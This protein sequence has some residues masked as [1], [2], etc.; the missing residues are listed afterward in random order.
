MFLRLATRLRAPVADSPAHCAGRLIAEYVAKVDAGLVARLQLR[1][2]PDRKLDQFF[3]AG[4][5]LLNIEQ[6][7]SLFD[8]PIEHNQL[9]SPEISGLRQR[10]LSETGLDGW[11]REID[12][13]HP[14][15]SPC[16]R[17][18]TLSVQIGCP[19]DLSN[20]VSRRLTALLHRHLPQ[21]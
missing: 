8:A 15:G 20:P 3:Q 1:V 18:A 9:I 21:Q 6:F 14:C 4:Q 2:Q 11:G 17:F 13:P 10:L 16:G 5:Y 19:A 12:S 7:S